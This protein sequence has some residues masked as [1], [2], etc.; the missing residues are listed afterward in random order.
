MVKRK[1][2]EGPDD[3]R[4]QLRLPIG[5]D[6]RYEVL[7]KKRTVKQVKQVGMGKT[8]N[9]SS[10]GV[11]FTTEAALREGERVELAIDWLA[12][13]DKVRLQLVVSG[14]LLRADQTQAALLIEKHEFKTQRQP[15]V[16]ASR[17]KGS[18]Q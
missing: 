3:R 5:L 4:T 14:R 8:L 2:R 6:V 7:G 16:T 11:L 1:P 12:Q 17:Q 18:R 15:S 9:M 10:G 13:L